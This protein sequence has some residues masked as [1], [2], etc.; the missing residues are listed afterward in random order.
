M[1]RPALVF[2]AILLL[3]VLAAADTSNVASSVTQAVVYP[4]GARVTRS[5]KV[6]LKEGATTIRFTGVQPNFDEGSLSVAGHG[7]AS[8]RILGAG[9]KTEFL[10]E[11]PDARVKE[12]NAAIEKLDDELA[13]LNGENTVLEQKKQFVESV[14]LFNGGELPKDLV[15]KVPTPE[16]LKGT[17]TFLEEGTAA[18]TIAL[19]ALNIKIRAKNRDRE[20]LTGEL[21]QLQ[22]AGQGHSERVLTA[23]MECD[24]AGELTLDVSYNVTQVSWYP[25]Y[26]ARV[27][28]EKGKAVVS[29]FAVVRQTTGEDWTN[30]PL[31]LSTARPS[32]GGVMPELSPMFLSLQVVRNTRSERKQMNA[33]AMGMMAESAT[34]DGLD[35]DETLFKRVAKQERSA[36]TSYAQAESSGAALI[37]KAAHPVVIRSDGSDVRVPLMSQ[38]L[39]ASF[40]YAAT[41]KL[42][43]YAYLRSSVTNGPDD[44]LLSGRVNAFLDGT[45]VG[46]SSIPKT[47]APTEAFDLYLGVDEG[48]VVKRELLDEKS[49]DTLIAGIPS[50]TRRIAYRFKLTVE[51]YKPRPATV[52]L[53][54]QVP[55]SQN[56]KIK[57]THVD[58]S[59]KPDTEKYKDREGVYNWTLTLQPRDKKEIILSYTVE[60]PRETTV[61]GL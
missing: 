4:S 44:Q 15:T 42:S 25:L 17:M 7:A 48:V 55:V 14:R 34:K 50:P 52:K 13:A 36:V 41:P 8:V 6:P 57:V 31:T 12:I 43:P 61:S 58:A 29:A 40:E 39:N 30:V 23:E 9:V 51:N 35:V 38:T 10:K 53:F 20:Q 5:V 1:I 2:S 54:D 33:P 32:A 3:P 21:G 11:S 56:E 28:F 49:D 16:E 18:Y 24:K 60:F 46:A 19:Q 47:I 22:A 45:Y 26:D 37:Y 27:E 59:V